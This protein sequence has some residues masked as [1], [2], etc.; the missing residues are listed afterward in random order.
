M[1]QRQLDLFGQGAEQSTPAQRRDMHEN[2]LKAYRA[3]YDQLPKK[4]K[5]V[6]D[7][8]KQLGKAT[9]EETAKHLGRYPNQVSGRFSELRKAGLIVEDGYK[10]HNNSTVAVWVVSNLV[11]N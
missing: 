11:N 3:I 2:S 7:T 10:I 6:L 8:I 1:E 4:R 9:I 5:Q